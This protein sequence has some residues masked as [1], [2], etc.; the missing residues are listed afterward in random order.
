[1]LRK[2]NVKIAHVSDCHLGAWRKESLNEMGYEAFERMVDICLEE[3]VDLVLISGDLYD[4]S[5][6]KVDVVDLATRQLRRLRDKNIPVYGIMGSHDFSPS[7]K[8]MLRPLISAGLFTNVSQAEWVE[9]EEKFPL[10][11][12]WIQD[13]KT[14][15]KLAGMR[16][17]KR[18]MEIE[19]YKILDLNILEAEE[20]IKIFLLH[21]MITD[22]KPED[23]KSMGDVSKSLLPKD[24]MYY[25]GGH[26]HETIPDTL[27][28]EDHVVI[29]EGMEIHEKVVYPGCL[30]PSNFRELEKFRYG[31]F[32]IMD[33]DLATKE[34]KVQFKLIKIKEVIPISIEASNKSAQK[35]MELIQEESNDKDVRDKIVPVRISGKLASGK[36][37]E[38]N[39][40]TI[41]S[42]FLDKGA[43]EV[44]INKIQLTSQEYENVN[45]G[46]QMTSE[47]IE[48]KLIFKHAQ[49]SN[50]KEL[51][52]KDIEEKIHQLLEALGRP[53]KDEEAKKDYTKLMVDNFY[54]VLGIKE[55]EEIT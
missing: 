43:L 6:P 50:F 11:L 51:S 37:I 24:C 28:F 36:P 5:N 52:K 10:R 46:P 23:Y 8:S 34:L 35:V 42:L 2:L 15:I 17:R 4:N 14:K 48:G 49:Q 40:S 3:K 25:A 9:N 41:T 22:L 21:T 38:I 30:F 31:G 44:L 18:S 55:E 12:K 19:D 1:M 32:C 53:I 45:V 7:D 13:E 29:S 16:A 20:G 47:E 39:P 26:L 27:R 33:A 54:H